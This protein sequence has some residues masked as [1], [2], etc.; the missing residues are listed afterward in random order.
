MTNQIKTFLLLALLSGLL[1]L[2]G[3]ALGGQT[4]LF[5]ALG[6]ALIM[7]VGSYWFSDKIVL[8]MYKA[9]PLSP[10]EA[11]MLNQMVEELSKEA[12]IPTPRLYIVPEQSPNAFA[13]GRNPE[14]A[15]LA[16][17]EGILRV[18]SHDELRGV[19]A[20]EIGHVVNRDILIQSIAAVL[21]TTIMY[22]AHMA[23]YAAIF[24][25][26]RSS[27]DRSPGGGLLSGL[28]LAILAP[29]AAMLIQMG[30]SRTREYKADA[31]GAR[32][33]GRPHALAS[34]LGKIS[35]YSKQVPLR[36][37]EPGTAHMFIISPLTGGLAGMFSTHPP[38]EERIKRLEAMQESLQRGE[39]L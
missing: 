22:L 30:I 34:A 37:K 36:E 8:T 17:T 21:A 29:I 5:I 20:H 39:A 31:T 25:A 12:G 10:T 11:P 2:L 9:R 4:G 3:R 35:Q 15:A 19:L 38:V 32:L 24:G 7:N 23:Q 26:G 16:V 6:I 18:L 33:S 1:L 14:H 28:L 27:D 13:T